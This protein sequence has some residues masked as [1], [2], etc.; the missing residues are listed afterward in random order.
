[1]CVVIGVIYKKIK[2]KRKSL[3]LKVEKDI[4]LAN[5]DLKYWV[6]NALN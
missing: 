2:S 3:S 4:V 5:L 6:Y 1:M